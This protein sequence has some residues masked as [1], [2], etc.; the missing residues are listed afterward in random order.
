MRTVHINQVKDWQ[1][2]VR[3]DRHTKWG[4]PFVIGRDGDRD[5]V[6]AL[7]RTYLWNNPELMGALNELKGKDLACWCAPRKCHA[8]VLRR[9]IA[10]KCEGV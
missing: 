4:N 9:A 1:N 7:Y 3:V 5:E 6:I 10:W 8:D 2:T